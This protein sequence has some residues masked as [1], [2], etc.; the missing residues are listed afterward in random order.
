MALIFEEEGFFVEVPPGPSF[1]EKALPNGCRRVRRRI[2]WLMDLLRCG[3]DLR[4]TCVMREA[5]RIVLSATAGVAAF[6]TPGLWEMSIEW[7]GAAAAAH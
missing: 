1:V 5:V 4:R 3:G 6:A 7:I 2:L